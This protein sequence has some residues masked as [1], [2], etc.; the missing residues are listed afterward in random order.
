MEIYEKIKYKIDKKI[1]KTV[2][3]WAP[4]RYAN[5]GDDLQAIAFAMLIKKLGYQVK[6][7][8]LDYSLAEEYGLESIATI[9]ELCADVNLCI[10]AGGALLTPFNLP[11]R[12]LHRAAVEYERDFKD[13]NNA[14][15]KYGTKFCAISIG[16]DGEER[17]PWL[18]YSRHRIDFFKSS[19]FLN[20]TVRLEGDILQMKKFGKD[21]VYYPDMLF[22]TAELFQY[23]RLSSTK[24]YRVGINF[25]KGKYLDNNLLSDIYEYARNHDDIEFHFTTTH[26]QKTGLNYQYLPEKESANIKIDIYESPRQLLGVLA[27]MDIFITSML[28]LG[29]TGLTT[30]TPFISYRGPGK[31]KSFLKSIGGEWAIVDN[32]ITFEQLKSNFFSKRKE[33][34]YNQY[35]T[36]IIKR[37]I[38]ES[39]YQYEYCTMIVKKFA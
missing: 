39:I 7:F 30:G 17:I 31:T 16:G 33:Q 15:K 25:K 35:D 20:G 19:N 32:N 4:L 3:I 37:M 27:S 6:L 14:S 29:L 12:L 2:A 10:I 5:Y 9:D 38:K 23:N 21:F 1:M 36:D 22:K 11:K 34:L 28:H 26:M 8:Q 24:K 13:L 18:Y